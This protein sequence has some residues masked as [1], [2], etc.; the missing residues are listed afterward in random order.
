MEYKYDFHVL[1]RFNQPKTFVDR[2]FRIKQRSTSTDTFIIRRRTKPTV[3]QIFD[4][5]I[6]LELPEDGFK[7]LIVSGGKEPIKKKN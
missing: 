3:S 1:Y 4:A 5:A 2:M 6:V 7:V